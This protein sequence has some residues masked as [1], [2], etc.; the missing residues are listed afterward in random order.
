MSIRLQGFSTPP[1]TPPTDYIEIYVDNADDHLKIKDDTGAITD[2][3]AAGSG[4]DQLTGD[5][6]A[7]GPGVVS[8]TVVLVGGATAANVAAATALANAATSSNTANTIVKRDAS[9]NFSAGTITAALSGN[10][11]TATSATT[12]TNFSGS[13]VGDVTGV[14]SATVVSTVGGSSA[15][16]VNTATV[17]VNTS[18]SG[19]KFLASPSGG[20]AGAPAFRAIVAADIPTLNQNTTGTA[21]NVTGVVVIANGGTN[22]SAA[23]NNNRVMKSSGG[24]IIEAAAITASRALASDAN[25]IPV[26]ATTTTTELNFVS[27][28][29]S[30]IQT[31]L[32][33]KQS[34][35][36]IVAVSGDVT[37]TTNAIHLV[38]S[39]AARN[40]TLPAHS[41]GQLI[42]IKDSTGSCQTN[43]FT[44]IRTGGGNI[45]GLAASRLLQTN[46]GSWMLVDDGTDWYMI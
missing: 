11:T 9:G 8:A 40:L 34:S 23:L 2:I 26:A 43:N 16:N 46:W 14:Q 24:A 19:N 13:L 18:Q 21:S 29:T 1:P 12:A 37:L 32:N 4:I 27:G 45:D 38:S 22:S 5:V 6:I 42:R 7:T 44:L 35:L 17:L 36:S 41:A 39:A 33:G 30:A 10:A 20:G 25:G 31:Q 3:T 15:A 28:V